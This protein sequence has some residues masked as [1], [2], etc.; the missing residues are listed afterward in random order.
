[1]ATCS[2]CNTPLNS[3]GS[4]PQCDAPGGPAQKEPLL[5]LEPVIL[6]GDPADETPPPRS[7]AP[8]PPV[9]APT[10]PESTPAADGPND[11]NDAPD[12]SA[13]PA[14]ADTA[15]TAAD[16]PP[17]ATQGG[18]APAAYDYAPRKSPIRRFVELWPGLLAL[19]GLWVWLAA[20]AFFTPGFFT[21]QS[22]TVVARSFLSM[23]PFAVA[24]A[25]TARACGPDFSLPGLASIC[26]LA[27][28]LAG[29]F[30][31]GVGVAMAIGLGVGLLNALLVYCLK[32][33]SVLATFAVGQLLFALASFFSGGQRLDYSL[34]TQMPFAFY[35]TLALIALAVGV[36]YNAATG[37]GV[38]TERRSM[39]QK[40]AASLF[41]A[42]PI[43]GLLAAFGA[44]Q[45]LMQNAAFTPGTQAISYLDLTFLWAAMAAT[46]AADGRVVPV[47]YA[48]AAQL[49]LRAF[50]GVAV[51]LGYPV[52]LISAGKGLLCLLMLL[53]AGIARWPFFHSRP[54]RFTD[55][56]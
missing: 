20:T 30:P 13:E 33:P 28:V 31:V 42:Y 3:D 27:V 35:I 18:A 24:L 43:A 21:A 40:R 47:L 1:M 45:V 23:A 8:E 50:S 49:F 25:L 22:L 6:G 5:E 26:M 11:P 39:R 9:Q 41:F 46:R 10:A 32:L 15:D 29:S 17:V 14:P 37:L 48:L 19:V 7:D 36:C 56:P 2:K 44:L 34:L 12:M 16:I 54:A 51:L 38:P 52:S 55:A 4:C 53:L